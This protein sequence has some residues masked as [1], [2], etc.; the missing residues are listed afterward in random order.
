MAD[1]VPSGLPATRITPS[2]HSSLGPKIVVYTV[3]DSRGPGVDP[4]APKPRST[5]RIDPMPGR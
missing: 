1:N 4:P 5:V 3:L 2:P